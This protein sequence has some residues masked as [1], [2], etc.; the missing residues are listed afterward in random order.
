VEGQ[1]EV[2]QQHTLNLTGVANGIPTQRKAD[3]AVMAVVLRP[4][5]LMRR[6]ARWL[7]GRVWGWQ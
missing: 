5:P 3:L 1:A 4:P 7:F 6:C 2:E